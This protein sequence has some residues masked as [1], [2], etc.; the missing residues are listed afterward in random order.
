MSKWFKCEVYKQKV[1]VDLTQSSFYLRICFGDFKCYLFV[2]LLLLRKLPQEH[3]LRFG[4]QHFKSLLSQNIKS[5]PPLL[6]GKPAYLKETESVLQEVVDLPKSSDFFL[7]GG[8]RKWGGIKS[9]W[10]IPTTLKTSK[11]SLESMSPG[12]IGKGSAAHAEE[13]TGRVCLQV[14]KESFGK[15][16]VSYQDRS[17]SMLLFW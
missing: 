2:L 8:G 1:C 13:K 11:F 17:I 7:G 3:Q 16:L 15:H 9:A 10:E 12:T 4:S 6:H 14:P 5:T